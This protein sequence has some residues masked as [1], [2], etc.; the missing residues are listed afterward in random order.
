MEALFQDFLIKN[1]AR[2]DR[3]EVKKDKE[4]IDSSDSQIS[5]K[6]RKR[7][8]LYKDKEYIERMKLQVILENN[9]KL[10]KIKNNC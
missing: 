5:D 8:P 3:E 7:V 2:I 10:K 4:G 1:N 9:E 6:P